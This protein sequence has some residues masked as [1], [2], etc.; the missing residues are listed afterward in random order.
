M[1]PV[2][3]G[4]VLVDLRDHGRIIGETLDGCDLGDPWYGIPADLEEH[5]NLAAR[6]P[7]IVPALARKE[8]LSS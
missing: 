7:E 1:P 8:V 2:A 4:E 3:S 6:H 5:A